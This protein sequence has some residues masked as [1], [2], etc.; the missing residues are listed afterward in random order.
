LL[1]TG[2]GPPLVLIPGGTLWF[3]SSRKIIPALAHHHTVYAV[4][5]PGQ[6]Y[7]EVSNKDFRH[8]LEAM[9]EALGSFMDALRVPRAAVVGHSGDWGDR[10]VLRRM[11]SPAGHRPGLDRLPRA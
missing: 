1:Q 8:D 5:M 2:T 10:A 7:T 9:S 3:Y 11:K 6:G 4:D